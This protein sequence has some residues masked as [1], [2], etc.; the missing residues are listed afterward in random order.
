MEALRELEA[1]YADWEQRIGLLKS[2]ESLYAA[3]QVEVSDERRAELEACNVPQLKAIHAELAQRVKGAHQAGERVGLLKSVETLCAAFEIELSDE[4]RAQLATL[5]LAQLEKMV[6][7][8]S[9]TRSWP[10]EV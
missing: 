10:G 1:V 7:T 6:V 9:K 8:I 4:R 3:S 2:I 5:D